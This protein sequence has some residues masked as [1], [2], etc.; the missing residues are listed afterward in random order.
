MKYSTLGTNEQHILFAAR[1]LR[2]SP[3]FV[4]VRIGIWRLTLPNVS[5][6]SH[7]SLDIKKNALAARGA[8]AAWATKAP[9][10]KQIGHVSSLPRIGSLGGSST[11]L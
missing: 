1:R 11:E 3:E 2:V 9:L 7:S 8:Q 5:L 4:V 10:G 6:L